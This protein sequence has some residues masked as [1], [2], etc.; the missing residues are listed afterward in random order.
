MKSVGAVEALHPTVILVLCIPV[1]LVLCTLLV[2]QG[3]AQSY[4]TWTDPQ[5]KFVIQYPPDWQIDKSFSTPDSTSVV[6]YDNSTSMERA[7]GVH[8]RLWNDPVGQ[9]AIIPGNQ[10]IYDVATLLSAS[11]NAPTSSGIQI[12]E[13]PE[14]GPYNIAGQKAVWTK[15]KKGDHEFLDV[16]TIVNRTSIH[17]TFDANEKIFDLLFPIAQTMVT[18]IQPHLAA[19]HT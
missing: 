15:Y 14:I 5:T 19:P 17:A 16:S 8:F 3:W 11:K 7:G 4:L 1:I 9:G 10:P 6:F 13:G 2:T 18:S 12:L